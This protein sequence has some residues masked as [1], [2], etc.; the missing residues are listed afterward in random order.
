M[1]SISKQISNKTIDIIS[2][3]YLGPVAPLTY[4]GN[5]QSAW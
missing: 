5:S 3:L 4:A 1:L 2:S